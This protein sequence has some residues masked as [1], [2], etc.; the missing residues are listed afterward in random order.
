MDEKNSSETLGEAAVL[1]RV[2]GHVG[3]LLA[4]GADT[5]TVA[6]VLAFVATELGLSFAPDSSE[7]YGVVLT[8]A[9]PATPD[10]QSPQPDAVIPVQTPTV[11]GPGE[12]VH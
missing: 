5:A 8:A 12:P 4:G 7:V 1:D 10:S 2:R 3:A 9:C 11:P 6:Y